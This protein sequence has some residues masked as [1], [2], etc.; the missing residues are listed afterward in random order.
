MIYYKGCKRNSSL[1]EKEEYPSLT[2]S[3]NALHL[4]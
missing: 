1:Q 4:L 2:H 3:V